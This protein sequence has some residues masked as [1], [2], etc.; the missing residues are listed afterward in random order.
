M[1]DDELTTTV[2]VTGVNVPA[3]STIG[4]GEGLDVVN[5][6][7]VHFTG[8]HRPM[9]EIAEAMPTAT[10]AISVKLEPWQIRR[11]IPAGQA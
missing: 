7:L 6:D 1:G 2:I 10:E 4:Y 11:R 8:D 5:G 9:R 3:M